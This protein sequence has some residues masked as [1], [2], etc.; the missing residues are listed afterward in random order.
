MDNYHICLLGISQSYGCQSKEPL[1]TL[2]ASKRDEFIQNPPLGNP[3]S[4][5]YNQALGAWLVT[6]TALGKDQAHARPSHTIR[7]RQALHSA[8]IS[9]ASLW[10]DC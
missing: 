7:G 5:F 3:L 4:G 10:E 1:V 2:S 6:T 9:L 8:T